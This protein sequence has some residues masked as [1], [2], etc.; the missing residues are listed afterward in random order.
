MFYCLIWRNGSSKVP[1][2][3]VFMALALLHD[4]FILLVLWSV[5]VDFWCSVLHQPVS[6]FRATASLSLH[7]YIGVYMNIRVCV[8]TSIDHCATIALWFCNGCLYRRH[9]CCT[10]VCANALSVR[11]VC[12][13]HCVSPSLRLLKI[14]Q[15]LSVYL[16]C[17]SY[18]Y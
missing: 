7:T 6:I 8:Y 2:K 14:S 10:T 3:S 18:Y 13:Q 4:Q 12:I 5:M 11:S 1:E 16:Y 17:D 15:F 9:R